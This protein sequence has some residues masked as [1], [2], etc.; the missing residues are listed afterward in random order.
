[1]AVKLWLIFISYCMSDSKVGVVYLSWMPF[2]TDYFKRFLDSYQKYVPAYPHQLVVVFNGVSKVNDSVKE[3]FLQ[4]LKEV[5]LSHFVQI[6][7]PSGQDVEIYKRIADTTDFDFLLFINT[8]SVILADQ[9]LK[10]Y[11]DNMNE[12]VGL[13]GATGSFA[14]YKASINRQSKVLLKSKISLKDKWGILKYLFKLNI[15]YGAQFPSFPNPHIRTNAFFI[16]RSLLS[17]L[18][19]PKIKS[20]MDAY[21]FENGKQSMTN[22]IL[23]RGLKCLVVD[24][25]GVS[26]DKDE[27]YSSKTFWCGNQEGLLISDNQTIKYAQANQELKGYLQFDA[28]NKNK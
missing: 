12:G 8:Y 28:W 24:K 4:V 3:A 16:K 27:W 23:Q 25:D 20:K 10:I 11:F 1:M 2:G 9:W 19:L 17:S 13:L 21:I 22:Q 14:S 18:I 6:E 5:R 26:W 7:F 15:L